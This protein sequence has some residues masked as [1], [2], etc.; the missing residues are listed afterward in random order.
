MW[1][2]FKN[3]INNRKG[4]IYSFFIIYFVFCLPACTSTKTHNSSNS[5]SSHLIYFGEKKST[6]YTNADTIAFEQF[7]S[8]YTELLEFKKHPN[9]KR[10]GFA[11]GGPY[12]KWLRRAKIIDNGLN[13]GKCA[14]K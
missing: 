12:Y 11:E 2:E 5:T 8:L 9:F 3:T 14:K 10:Y 6:L 13:Y 7:L 4:Y 1:T